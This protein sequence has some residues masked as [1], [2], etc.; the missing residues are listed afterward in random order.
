MVHGSGHVKSLEM[1]WS[2]N[3]PSIGPFG[4]ASLSDR[5]VQLS[6]VDRRL[7]RLQD[8]IRLTV[9][10]NEPLNAKGYAKLRSDVVAAEDVWEQEE[11]ESPPITEMAMAALRREGRRFA[12]SLLSSLIR[13]SIISHSETAA[14]SVIDA[15]EHLLALP[16]LAPTVVKLEQVAI[17]V[18]EVVVEGME[19]EEA[20]AVAIE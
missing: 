7:I 10:W 5:L 18:A 11:E 8:A 19:A 17:G 12:T 13:S 15:L 20:A 16:S 6:H 2:G 4:L 14:A 3:R 1:D 9:Q